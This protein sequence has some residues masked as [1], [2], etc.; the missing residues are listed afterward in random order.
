MTRVSPWV[1]RGS[2]LLNVSL[3]VYLLTRY[4]PHGL[5]TAANSLF[6]FEG[7]PDLALWS[8]YGLLIG[9]VTLLAIIVIR[10]IGRSA[11]VAL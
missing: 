2:L 7:S 6:G 1:V 10:D 5:Q 3:I 9:G 8:F 4:D 11:R